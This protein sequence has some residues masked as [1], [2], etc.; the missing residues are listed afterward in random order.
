[1]NDY[2][3]RKHLRCMATKRPREPDGIL[4]SAA[5]R[6]RPT[7]NKTRMI[8]DATLPKISFAASMASDIVPI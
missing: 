5:L 2:R 8:L 6:E 3:I 1:M 4:G 7:H